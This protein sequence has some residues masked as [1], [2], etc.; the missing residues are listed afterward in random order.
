[1]S[2]L[3]RIYHTAWTACKSN[4]ALEKQVVV[5]APNG[6]EKLQS[7][8]AKMGIECFFGSENDLVNR[9][10]SAVETYEANA[11]VRITGDCPMLPV[12]M[13]EECMKAL[14]EVDYAANTI[15]R[16]FPEGWDI[17]GCSRGALVWFDHEQTSEREHLFKPFDEN[18]A[19]RSRFVE[20]GYT[21]RH[22]LNRDNVIFQKLSVDTKEDLTRI[23]RVLDDEH[24][25]S[26]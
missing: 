7:F 14:M 9:Y 20:A 22:I 18:A 15:T 17:Q 1:M 13:I 8:C 3:E 10:V 26:R 4:R 11:V 24:S 6:D 23:R 25:R 16:S 2:I 19:M 12:T 5:L 21:Y